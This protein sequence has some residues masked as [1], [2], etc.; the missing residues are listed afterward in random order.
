MLSLF[1]EFQE[2]LNN[3]T[4]EF[5]GKI[6]RDFF[7]KITFF[8][9]TKGLSENEIRVFEKNVKKS[10]TIFINSVKNEA[11]IITFKNTVIFVESYCLRFLHELFSFNCN[12]KLF[13]INQQAKDSFDNNIRLQ[14]Q[15]VSNIIHQDEIYSFRENLRDYFR[16]SRRSKQ[17]SPIW[18]IIDPCILGNEIMEAYNKLGK[19]RINKFIKND[20]SKIIKIDQNEFIYLRDIAVGSSHRIQ[21]IYHIEKRELFTI[22]I[23]YYDNDEHE[24]LFDRELNNYKALSHPFMPKLLGK[25]DQGLIIEY[26][27]G[28]TLESIQKLKLDDS[29]KITIIFELMIIIEF[30]H[31]NKFILRDLKPRDIIIDENMNVV[32]VD[33]DR[34]ISYREIIEYEEHTCDFCSVYCSPDVTNGLPIAYKCDIYS[35][36]MIIYLIMNEKRPPCNIEENTLTCK[37]HEMNEIIKICTK[38]S[39]DERPSILELIEK[40]YHQFHSQIKFD[41]GKILDIYKSYFSDIYDINKIDYIQQQILGKDNENKKLYNGEYEFKIGQKN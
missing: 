19:N 10:S 26:I 6:Q 36:G 17:L 1:A 41:V 4:I 34:M 30:I 28:K 12:I 23:S 7:K 39:P 3:A 20:E 14:Y 33:F 11:F 9:V 32:L 2:Q 31:R 22:K 18:K 24:K 38:R 15:E 37:N 5:P 27:N 29:D 21:L 40:F 8:S 35:L 13:F 25:S 16:L